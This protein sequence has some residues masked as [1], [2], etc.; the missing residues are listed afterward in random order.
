MYMFLLMNHVLVTYIGVQGKYKMTV[1][2]DFPH[3]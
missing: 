2:C 3:L 1:C